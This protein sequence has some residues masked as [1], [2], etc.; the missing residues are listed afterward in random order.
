MTIATPSDA[1]RRLNLAAR[2]ERLPLTG[3]QKKLFLIIAMAWLFDSIDIASLTFVLA[4]ISEE[5]GLT[6]WEAGLLASSSF[7]GMAIGASAAG[8][9]GDR[10]G[11][12]PVFVS[13][14]ICWGLASLGLFFSWD[15]ASLLVFR[16]MLGLGMGAEFPLAQSLLSEFAPTEHRGRLLG[17]LEGFWPIGFITA[18]VLAMVLVPAFGW[19]SIFLLQAVFALWALF[20]RRAVPES[21]RWYEAR[22]YYDKA[23][24]AISAFEAKV[25][26]SYGRE[27]PPP[28]AYAPPVAPLEGAG[29]VLKELLGKQYRGRTLLAW[30][31]WFCVQLGYYGITTWIA[32]L[33]AD[34]SFSITGSIQYV[35][36]MALWGIPGFLVASQLLE[37]IGRKPIVVAFVVGSAISAFIYGQADS[38]AQL[39]IAGSLMQ[40]FLFGMWSTIYAYTPELF[41]TRARATG[42]GT[43]SAIGRI[44]AILGP[45]TVPL[46]MT[47]FGPG[48]V[49]VVSAITFVAAAVAV[50]LFGPETRGLALEEVSR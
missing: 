5:F 43:S 8:I 20:A 26:K 32:K 41:P 29:G 24:E 48:A 34:S 28:A 36:L 9:L 40:F 4:P 45:L 23:E 2:M 21:A 30:G 31:M 10:I 6:G 16:F 42:C 35:V 17:W 44:G 46:L 14:M 18:G 25:E 33:L 13:S 49:F 38:T 19:R 7:A 47:N 37:R 1:A 3:Y 50:L 39:L 22:G 11:R 12:R 27:L 15:L